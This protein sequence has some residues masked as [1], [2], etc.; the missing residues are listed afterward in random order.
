MRGSITC[1]FFC[2]GKRQN[3]QAQG[4]KP[5]GKISRQYRA[6]SISGSPEVDA[7]AFRSQRNFRFGPSFRGHRCRPR[8][9]EFAVERILLRT[10]EAALESGA[11]STFLDGP[12]SLD[13]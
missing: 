4:H 3:E 12:A 1:R 11:P 7:R 9:G 2:E 5:D 8:L 10:L 6:K 13:R